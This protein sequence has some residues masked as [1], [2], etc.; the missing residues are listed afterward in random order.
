METLAQRL[1]HVLS[2][3]PA[4]VAI[5]AEGRRWTWQDI[6]CASALVEQVLRTAGTAADAPV[7]WMAHNR[8]TSVVSFVSLVMNGRMVVPL[9]PRQSATAL[10]TEL[11]TQ[12]L[13]AVI[14]HADDWAS[15]S[16]AAAARDTG[17]AGIAL[18]DA[19]GFSVT[20]VAGLEFVGAA[21]HR[22][23]MPGFVME[24][25]TSG[26]TG[27]P[28]RVPVA[29]DVLLP[30]LRAGEQ[31]G[32]T[33]TGGETAPSKSPAILLKPFSH[34]G[35]LFGL[36]L[37]LYQARPMVLMDRFVP[38]QWAAVVQQY[39]PKAASLVPAMIRMILDE[40]I[41]PS[42]LGSLKAIRS[43]T[44]PL[45]P[46][47]Q[48]EFERRYGI[49]ILV[50][51]GAAEFIGGIAGWSLEDHR[52][53]GETKRGSVGRLRRDV[54]LRLTSPLTGEDAQEGAVG[55]VNLRSP[56]FGDGWHRTSDL[57]RIDGDGFL[58]LEGRVDDAINR[59]GFKIMPEEVVKA[60]L[61]FPGVREAVV[62]GL[63][64]A[65]LGEVPVAAV[66]LA[67]DKVPPEPSILEHHL[68]QHLAP[69]MIPVAFQFPAELPRTA[70][71]KIDRPA[72]RALF[73]E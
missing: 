58:F 69:Y 8:A 18:G 19:D 44:A 23:P 24:R 6:A 63:P 3:D 45:D 43:G 62:V 40:A 11:E 33:R 61:Q 35:G 59:G 25:L 71:M 42:M 38:A 5:E 32:G 13:E 17:S 15:G 57:A 60:L 30:A 72:V 50:D 29:E 52:R 7:G 51:Y 70:S 12:R 48:V 2:L 37:A 68:R 4:A 73:A 10:R 65:R 67:T 56:R 64:D 16:M 27:P 46:R 66:Q 31:S 54:E 26:T 49:P 9:R 53:F 22:A 39:R 34:A 36:L 41:D 20:R 28:K 55:V 21:D 47:M 1:R 14:A